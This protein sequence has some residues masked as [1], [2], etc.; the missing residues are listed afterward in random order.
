[1]VQAVTAVEAQMRKKTG[2]TEWY[3]SPRRGQDVCLS[4]FG[5]KIQFYSKKKKCTW[6]NGEK[7]MLCA[8]M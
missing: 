4:E 7:N 3:V 1:M 5:D 2:L 6:M 8:E